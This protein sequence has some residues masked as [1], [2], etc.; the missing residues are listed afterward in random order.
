MM[1][2]FRNIGIG[3]APSTLPDYPYFVA[4]YGTATGTAFQQLGSDDV[5]TY[6]CD[7]VTGVNFQLRGEIPNPVP[8]RNLSTNPIGT[9]ILIKV[10]NGNPLTV[11]SAAM[12]NVATGAVV[13]LRP[14]VTRDNDPNGV[15]GGFG[16]GEAYVAPDAPL[17]RGTQYQVT[18]A[19]T[20]NGVAFSRSFRF[21]TG[22]GVN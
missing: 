7:G 8:G 22:T 20:N 21:T 15:A 14:P 10:R 13:V 11:T 6:P 2:G 18:V 12:I 3:F 19:G 16:P 17:E 1:D 9:P 4:N 5:A